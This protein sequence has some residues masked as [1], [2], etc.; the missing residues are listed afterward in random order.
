MKWLNYFHFNVFWGSLG[1]VHPTLSIYAGPKMIVIK[2]NLFFPPNIESLVCAK[3]WRKTP[4]SQGLNILEEKVRNSK[5]KKD[6]FRYQIKKKSKR[7]RFCK[8]LDGKGKP[9]WK[10]TF[11][12]QYEW[13]KLPIWKLEQIPFKQEKYVYIKHQSLK[14]D[15]F[16]MWW[17]SRRLWQDHENESGWGV[18]MLSEF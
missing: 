15:K 2:K 14:P 18:M 11:E 6:Y 16:L 9:I 1:R 13:Q 12:L 5:W 10:A 17:D 4:H 8:W 7:K 3:Q